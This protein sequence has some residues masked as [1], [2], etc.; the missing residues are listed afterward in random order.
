MSALP[1]FEQLKLFTRRLV[2]DIGD[3]TNAAIRDFTQTIRTTLSL[4]DLSSKIINQIFEI[5]DAEDIHILD[6]NK[7]NQE[8]QILYHLHNS[9]PVGR[10]FS[11]LLLSENDTI[12]RYFLENHLP[13]SQYQIDY[14]ESFAN[15]P[16]HI[17][18]WLDQSGADIYVP[19]IS[20]EQW[21]G[22]IC[23]GPKRSGLPYTKS[24]EY[25]LISIADQTAIAYE[26]ARLINGLTRLNNDYRR[27]YAALEKTNTQLQNSV[28]KLEKLDRFKSD[29]ITVLS[30]ELRTPMTLIAGYAQL[31]IDEPKI[32][33]NSD[34]GDILEGINTG[35]E[36]LEEI[37][38]AILDMASI[39]SHT[40]DLR[41]RPTSLQEIMREINDGLREITEKRQIKIEI[42]R[43]DTLPPIQTDRQLLKKAIYQIITNSIKYSPDNSEI[44]VEGIHHAEPT[45]SL[46]E[47]AVELQITD[48]G[49]GIDPDQLDI[50]FE[51]L[52]QV[53]DVAAHSSG[54]T[55]YKGGGPG[56][57]LAIA[58][59]IIN[60][61]YGQLW[62][63][64]AGHDEENFPGST[65]HLLLPLQ[66]DPTNQKQIDES[67]I[68]S[69]EES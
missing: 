51:K 37:V 11:D 13:L 25:F 23:L 17:R 27:A 56:L 2:P 15:L 30:H 42:I 53:G 24:E 45:T 64:S 26:N 22:L 54:K 39:D 16:Q 61:L 66:R 29:L 52:Y 14:L 62:A 65:F 28:R 33:E 41:I 58:K 60:E 49:I 4:E 50:V 12:P 67:Q 55:K 18:S 34:W 69:S 57:G 59:G 38:T 19:I 6:I 8:D 46:G 9:E 32:M 1:V 63:E 10:K 48:H 36:R 44:R 68:K 31:L 40:L 21:I 35:T 7:E 43:I 5:I 3:Q 47:P 20:K